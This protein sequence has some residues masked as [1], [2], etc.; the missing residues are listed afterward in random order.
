MKKFV[1]GI[2]RFSRL[3]NLHTYLFEAANVLLT[4]VFRGRR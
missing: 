1:R 2:D 4:R 3:S